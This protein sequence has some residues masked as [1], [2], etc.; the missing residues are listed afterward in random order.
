MA[1]RLTPAVHILAR[2][3]EI[4]VETLYSEGHSC[5][6]VNQTS[7]LAWALWKDC[8]LED[9]FIG[10]KEVLPFDDYKDLVRFCQLRYPLTAVSLKLEQ[11]LATQESSPSC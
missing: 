8:T 7:H 6:V 11:S 9:L 5:T 4:L 3:R 2:F 1:S 10:A